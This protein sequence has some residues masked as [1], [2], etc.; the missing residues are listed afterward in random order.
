MVT[1]ASK[2]THEFSV[3]KFVIGLQRAKDQVEL[4][5]AVVKIQ[6]EI[7]LRSLSS[8]VER[9][10]WLRFHDIIR[11]RQKEFPKPFLIHL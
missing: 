2:Q 11:W 3:L 8:F 1:Q 10:R 7:K 4:G 6:K 9:R 5:I